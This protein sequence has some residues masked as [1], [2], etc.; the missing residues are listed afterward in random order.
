MWN[1]ALE[2]CFFDWIEIIGELS[3]IGSGFVGFC[4]RYRCKE[5]CC[6]L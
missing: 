1:K 4:L 5:I 2:G 6:A 3:R